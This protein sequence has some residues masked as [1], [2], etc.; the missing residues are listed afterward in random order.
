M[1]LVQASPGD[2]SLHELG[3]KSEPLGITRYLRDRITRITSGALQVSIVSSVVCDIFL[4]VH[5]F[6]GLAAFLTA[7]ITVQGAAYYVIKRLQPLEQ[8]VDRLH[9]QGERLYQTKTKLDETTRVAKVV[10]DDMRAQFYRYRD[11]VARLEQDTEVLAPGIMQITAIERQLQQVEK[12]LTA[13]D[14]DFA[15]TARDLHEQLS[16]MKV[17]LLESER[18]REGIQKEIR[19]LETTRLKLTEEVDQMRAIQGKIENTG[20][21][22]IAEL[23]LVGGRIAQIPAQLRASVLASK[24]EAAQQNEQIVKLEKLVHATAAKEIDET[25]AS[26]KGFQSA[27]GDTHLDAESMARKV[28]GMR[29][30]KAKSSPAKTN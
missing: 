14:A 28:M 4:I 20:A 24:L 22:H 23:D 2:G 1:E 17:L 15:D 13:T 3:A 18:Q 30:A 5:A 16:V 29:R 12:S 26:L 27:I 7:V 21:A 19:E 10:T 9:E 11:L 8:Q 25:A 6:S